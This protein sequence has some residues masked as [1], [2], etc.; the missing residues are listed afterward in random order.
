MG[1]SILSEQL[2]AWLS[3]RDRAPS[4]ETD[5]DLPPAN[6]AWYR[7]ATQLPHLVLL[8]SSL[9]EA[10]SLN[11]LT[12]RFP[13]LLQVYSTLRRHLEHSGL[14]VEVDLDKQS[15]I[16]LT[17]VN[18][19][20]AHLLLDAAVPSSLARLQI[21]ATLLYE[22]P[23]D[24]EKR[25]M[26]A[27]EQALLLHVIRSIAPPSGAFQ[28]DYQ[29]TEDLRSLADILKTLRE[30]HGTILPQTDLGGGYCVAA[31]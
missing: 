19:F 6:D 16:G 13:G 28:S 11:L 29:R 18:P 9:D 1:D 27:P 14:F 26:D 8:F 31:H 30:T 5:T 21:L 10:I 15:D 4:R 2:G 20:V 17:T 25:P 23:W 7:I 22:F 12:K 24:A 3:K